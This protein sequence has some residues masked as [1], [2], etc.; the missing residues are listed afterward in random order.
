MNNSKG[1]QEWYEDIS[2]MLTLDQRVGLKVILSHQD[3]DGLF[4]SLSRGLSE[5]T[6][7]LLRSGNGTIFEENDNIPKRRYTEKRNRPFEQELPR[8]SSE[9]YS[10]EGL[11]RS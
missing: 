10:V 11:R 9:V 2:G 8:A 4:H 5:L 6:R 1:L 7:S 3:P